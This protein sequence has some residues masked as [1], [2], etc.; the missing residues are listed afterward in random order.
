LDLSSDGIKQSEV[1]AALKNFGFSTEEVT[2]ALKT[3]KGEGKTID[4]KIRLVLKY[5]GK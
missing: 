5:L 2:T 1:V 4:E 3:L